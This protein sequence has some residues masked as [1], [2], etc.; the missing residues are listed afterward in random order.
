MQKYN[1]SKHKNF[2][3][4]GIS[5]QKA[6]AKTRGKFNLNIDQRKALLDKAKSIGLISVVTS[7]TCN[8]TEI[9]AFADEQ[10]V[11]I[12]LLCEFS[13]GDQET[14][15][16][17]GY[18][19]KNEAAINHMF[20]VGGGL[21]SQ[22]LGDFEIISQ[23]KSAFILSKKKGMIN[24]FMERLVNS[25]IQASRRIKNETRIS[26]G[27][28]SVSF[29][30][31]QYILDHIEHVSDRKILLFG[32][33]KIG[34]NTCENLV[35]HTSNKN[36][37][38]INRTKDKAEEIAGKFNLIVKDFSELQS[39]IRSTDILI[40]ATG[41]QSP[42]I[43]KELIYPKKDLLVLDLS[44]PK[45]VAEDVEGMAN[46]KLLHLDYLSQL[47]DENL[48]K[49]KAF[50]PDAEAII[51]EVKVEFDEWLD[52]RKFAPTIKALKEKFK[53]FQ[54]EELD[55]QGKKNG[56]FDKEQAEL[57]SDRVIHKITRSFASHL[58]NANGSTEDSIALLKKVF[59]LETD[60]DKA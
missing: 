34:R 56:K 31:V 54:E 53:I 13:I 3:V 30:S 59:E 43:T 16:E 44:I 5:Y 37:T 20:R 48:S 52:T 15:S 50:I 49:R 4:I 27:A 57:I 6:D 22:I 9:Y 10:D 55:Y 11:L 19:L 41:A 7:S 47:T 36:I 17:N 40:V 45:N 18:V 39:E 24:H 25:V 35:K 12:D 32:T 8:R 51:E 60:S 1:V 23:I 14:F 21:D 46:V 29:A 58:R 38:L 2:Y 33:G 42:T 28:T 26:S